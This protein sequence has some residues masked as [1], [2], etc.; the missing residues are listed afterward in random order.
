MLVVCSVLV[1]GRVLLPAFWDRLSEGC[2]EVEELELLEDS[3]EGKVKVAEGYFKE[4]S[5]RIYQSDRKYRAHF[6][7]DNMYKRTFTFPVRLVR[8]SLLSGLKFRDSRARLIFSNG[9]VESNRFVL[10]SDRNLTERASDW[11]KRVQ[12]C[13]MSS[14]GSESRSHHR[15]RRDHRTGRSSQPPKALTWHSP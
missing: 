2:A 4:V 14:A 5:K 7:G 6:D 9:M 12:D 11:S 13:A 10:F 8:T 15:E 3:I 1:R